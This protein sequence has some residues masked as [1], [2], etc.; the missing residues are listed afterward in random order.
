MSLRVETFPVG[1]LGCNCSIVIDG[2][3]AVVID[4]G[5]DFDKITGRLDELGA[6]VR[7]IVHTHTHIDH[8]GA[9]APLARH[10]GVTPQ[11]HEADRFLYDMLPIQAA[12][13]G[14]VEPERCELRGDLDDERTIRVGAFEIAV[15]HTP[16]HTPGSVTFVVEGSEAIAFTGDTLFR[17]SIG[18][19][20]LWGGD[21]GLILRSLKERLMR[22]DDAT[23]VIPGHGPGSTIAHER[24]HN[25]FLRR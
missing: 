15:L 22:L 18:R 5:G 4:P 8:V 14:V 17:G 16:G 23:R 13:V 7:A 10:A 1:P 20:D 12:L 2:G 11:I 25:P 21:G 6:T 19:T 24:G 3:E 9:T